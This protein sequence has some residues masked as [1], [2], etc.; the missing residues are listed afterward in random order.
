MVDLPWAAAWAPSRRPARSP[1]E[2]IVREVSEETSL[3]ILE[4]TWHGVLDLI[5]GVPEQSR[6]VVHV[7]RA[8]R[9]AGQARGT[10]GTLRWY[11]RDR[12]PW[13]LMWLDQRYWLGSVLDGGHCGARARSTL[14]ATS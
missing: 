9:F 1:I 5:F 4:P 6:L 10:A 12:L 2:A 13:D 14:P 11:R 3:R 8:D 7:F